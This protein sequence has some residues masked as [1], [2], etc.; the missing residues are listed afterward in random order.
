GL[1]VNYKLVL[2]RRLH[3]KVGRFLALEDAIDVAGSLPKL[4]GRILPVGHQSAG[5]DEGAFEVDG[6]QPILRRK[7]DDQVALNHRTWCWQHYQSSVRGL[8][9]SRDRAP[10]VGSLAHVD[11]IDFYP[12]R[13][14]HRR[15]DTEQG[16]AGWCSGIAKGS[17]SRHAGRNLFEQLQPFSANTIFILN[18][19]R[20]LRLADDLR[21][22][23]AS[24]FHNELL[25]QLERVGARLQDRSSA[26]RFLGWCLS[27]PP[28]LSA[29]R[30]RRSAPGQSN[31]S[32]ILLPNLRRRS[33]CP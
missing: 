31:V 14:R 12:E 25:P 6:W 4:I 11:M 10:N 20:T 32:P 16:G 22:R 1:E 27:N 8:R 33:P 3:W 18:A 28:L 5:S 21:H 2:G 26:N 19:P 13:R 23:R 29:S 24:S 30:A 17:H 9:K 15:D 7:L